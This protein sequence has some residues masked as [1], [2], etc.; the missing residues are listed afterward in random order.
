MEKQEITRESFTEAMRSAVEERGADYVYIP[1]YSNRCEYTEADG[2]VG[3]I[4]GLALFKLGYTYRNTRLLGNAC[5][6]SAAQLLPQ[7][8]VSDYGL[9][10]AAEEAQRNQDST[11]CWGKAFDNY[12]KVLA[13]YHTHPVDEEAELVTKQ[14]I[15]R[16]SFTEAMEASVE[17]RGAGYI[18]TDGSSDL[19][20]YTEVDG[21]PGCL[22]GLALSKLGYTGSNTQYLENGMGKDVGQ[23]FRNLAVSDA[24]LTAAAQKAQRR[25]D[26]GHSWGSALADYKQVLSDHITFN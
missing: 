9:I 1:V 8:G 14:E 19:C 26:N 18:Y 10:R 25:Q 21:E 15:T 23:V 17:E 2:S 3:C 6:Q 7:I 4:I 12:E 20:E 13:A 16:E 22:I 24:A 11:M 5:G